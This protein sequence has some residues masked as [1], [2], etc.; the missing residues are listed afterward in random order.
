MRTTAATLKRRNL[1]LAD[2]FFWRTGERCN[3]AEFLIATLAYQISISIPD[4]RLYIERA[5]ERDPHI[6]SK[7]LEAQ[8]LALIVDPIRALFHDQNLPSNYPR[9]F[10]VDGLDECLEVEARK[11]SK[12]VKK[13]V[14]VL[15]VLHRVLKLLPAPFYLLIASRPENHIQNMFDT[16]LKHNS[17]QIM[18]NISH[19]ADADIRRFYITKFREIRKHHP[20]RSCL[21]LSEWPSQNTLNELVFRASGQ[22]IYASTVIKFVSANRNNPSNQLSAILDVNVRGNTRPFQDRKSVV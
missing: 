14:E 20:L 10:L 7:T 1:L 21:P 13:Q 22:F 18:L 6:F 3:H 12:D 2:F 9:V 4:T 19:N 15:H 11:Q 5:V 8:S 16:A 17:S